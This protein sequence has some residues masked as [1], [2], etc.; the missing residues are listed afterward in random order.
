MVDSFDSTDDKRVGNNPVGAKT[1][2]IDDV[3]MQYRP[4]T[5]TEKDELQDIKETGQEF[6]NKIRALGDVSNEDIKDA[7][8]R[9][10]E[11]VMFAVRYI[12]GP[13]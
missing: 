8:R 7:I 6:I 9:A 13:K 1:Y 2:P 11:S 5:D 4:L 12:T 3:R 10:Q